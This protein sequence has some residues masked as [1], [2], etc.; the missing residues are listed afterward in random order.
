MEKTREKVVPLPVNRTCVEWH[1]KAV[2]S[3]KMFVRIWLPPITGN[4]GVGESPLPGG[5]TWVFK[6]ES[7]VP[8]SRTST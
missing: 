2:A 6:C 7:L 5:N 3:G 8:L 1:T 4:G